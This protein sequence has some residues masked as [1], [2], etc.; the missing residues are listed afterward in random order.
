MNYKEAIEVL[1]NQAPMFRHLGKSAYKTGLE[2][3]YRLDEML[4]HRHREY[5]TVHVAGTNG[6]G[7][8]SHITAAV[9][10]SAGYK[11][12][13]YTSPHLRDFRERIRVDGEMI[14]EEAVCC[15]VEKM[16]PVI[17][18][19]HPSFFE[20][21]TA[22]AFDYFARRQVDVAVIEVGLGGRLDCTNIITPEVS[23]ITN[24]SLD[25]TDLL[26]DTLQAIARE[27][28]G[29]IKAGVPVVIGETQ[30]EVAGIFRAIASEEGTSIVFADQAK[31]DAVLPECEMRGLYQDKNRRTVLAVV[32]TLRE[33]GFVIPDA[34]VAEGFAHV[35]SLT[36]IMGRWQTLSAAPRVVCDTGHNV[37]GITFVVDQL[38][39]ERYDTLRIVIG[40]VADKDITHILELLPR[41][42]VYYFT[43]ASIPRALAAEA[44]KERAAQYGLQGNAYH[45]VAEALDA[46]KHDALEAAKNGADDLVF[47]GGSN[48]T[49]GEVVG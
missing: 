19:L 35:C 17:G 39:R 21:T 26:G 48:F 18:E 29:V 45:T 7:S 44:L 25:H 33:R 10:Q 4:R 14:S 28:A 37:A 8:T 41:Q 15:F 24:I 46:A 3:T 20:I 30:A 49:V 31:A 27:K 2:T 34:A 16:Q 9:L 32:D 36:G 43:N 12:G 11:V 42:A 38:G 47:V 5:K 6:K 13:L 1:Y 22:L 23:V 40:M